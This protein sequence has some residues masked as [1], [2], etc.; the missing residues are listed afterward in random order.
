MAGEQLHESR[1]AGT[2]LADDSVNLPGIDSQADIL[3]HL[4]R[5]EG[6]RQRD[7]LQRRTSGGDGRLGA[8]RFHPTL[9]HTFPAFEDATAASMKR[10]P[11]KPSRTVG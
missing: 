1:L 6:L 10:M 8:C 9:V 5:A 4:D 2:I 11:A 3:Q 7:R